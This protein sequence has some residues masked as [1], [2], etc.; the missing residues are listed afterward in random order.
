MG[1]NWFRVHCLQVL[2]D[3]LPG[4]KRGKVQDYRVNEVETFGCEDSS[5]GKHVRFRRIMF[6]FACLT[7]K[8]EPHFLPTRDNILQT[9]QRMVKALW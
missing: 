1:L 3:V 7:C 9:L 5:L 2:Y 6:L 4:T 8:V